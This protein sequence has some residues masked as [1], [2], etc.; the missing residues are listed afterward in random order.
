MRR[1]KILVA[2]DES[3]IRLG[4]RTML[5]ELGHEVMLAANGREA[6]QLTRTADPDLALLDINMPLTDGLEAARAIGRKHPMPILILTAYSQQDLI[7]RAAQ[8]PI[9][10]Y[11]VKPVNEK[12]LAAAIEVAMARFEESQAAAR[13]VAELRQDLDTRKVVDQ[14][15]EYRISDQARIHPLP[16]R[17]PVPFAVLP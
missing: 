17:R 7:E 14:A 3:I 6:L 16:I 12:E 2:D 5:A 1:L 11:L 13:E 15:D 4:L 10:G 8:L 9:Q